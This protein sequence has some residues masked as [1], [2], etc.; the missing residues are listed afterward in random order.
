MA[1]LLQVLEGQVRI[2]DRHGNL[3]VSIKAITDDSR[4][5]SIDSL[6]VAV[7]GERV[8]GHE[9]IPAA[10]KRRHGRIGVATAGERGVS[11][12]RPR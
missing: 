12:I 3:D 6:F 5:V 11:S 1:T 10:V 8:D 2:L 7:K 9:F 4:A